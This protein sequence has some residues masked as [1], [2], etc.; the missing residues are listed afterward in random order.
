M[1]DPNYSGPAFPCQGGELLPARD[2]PLR[3]WL[4]GQA[5]AGLIAGYDFEMRERSVSKVR[6]GFDDNMAGAGSSTWA[7]SLASDARLIADAML[8]ELSEG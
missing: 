1:N 5:I 7:Q 4:A 3:V 2:M 6:T 8:A